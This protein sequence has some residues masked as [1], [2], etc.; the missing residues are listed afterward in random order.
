MII[1]GDAAL[2]GFREEYLVGRFIIDILSS[3][4]RF[5]RIDLP[6][7]VGKSILIDKII[8][9]AVEGDHYDL[10]IVMA[11]TRR[12]LEERALIRKPPTDFLVVNLRPRPAVDCGIGANALWQTLERQGMAALG[13]DELCSCCLKERSCYWPKQFKKDQIAGARVIFAAQA[14]L[15]RSA[16][17]LGF[18]QTQACAERVLVLIDEGNFLVSPFKRI[19][20]RKRLERFYTALKMSSRRGK[21]KALLRM[22]DYVEVLLSTKTSDLRRPEW[23]VCPLWPKDHL[24]VSKA[25]W[26]LFEDDFWNLGHEIVQLGKSPLESRAVMAN[27]DIRFAAPPAINQDFIFFSGTTSLDLAVHRLGMPLHSPFAGIQFK[28]PDTVWYNIASRI[29]MK[30]YFLRNAPQIF[31]FFGELLLQRLQGGKRVVLLAKKHYVRFCTVQM[32]ER[33][34]AAGLGRY[35]V[36]AA[37]AVVAGDPFQVPMLHYGLIG[38][39]DFEE[40][41]CL[42]SL[43]GFYV[44]EK[45]VK[46][47]LDDVLA[48]DFCLPIEIGTKGQP[49]RRTAGVKRLED[50]LYE[51]HN[52]AQRILDEQEGGVIVQAVGRIRPFTKPRE[53]VTFHCGQLPGVIYDHEF[54]S[55]AAA[56]NHFGI[57]NRRQQGK[58]TTSL[59]VR[60]FKSDGKTQKETA[61]GLKI[62]LRTVQR[63]W[64]E[65]D[66][67]PL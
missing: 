20:Q 39:N 46:T 21:R 10:I 65:V 64:G 18:L 14:H 63:H 29:G 60:Q 42:L 61:A 51:N 54:P 43:T 22:R 47:I 59:A 52:L 7:G 33:L 5:L 31:D 4:K 50:R 44:N 27:G 55:L 26:E 56:R 24:N 15:E 45:V 3:G 34:D 40:Y 8:A 41:D 37:K 28:H 12:I 17:I 67:N 23:R 13:K 25:G 57:G 53:V 11:P 66:T 2:R 16:E 62:S 32:Q 6:V 30:Q 38:V 49:L 58:Q 35:R 9:T 1:S 36:V 48:E 19:L